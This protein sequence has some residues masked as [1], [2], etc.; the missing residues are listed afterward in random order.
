MLYASNG[1]N[2]LTGSHSDPDC[3]RVASNANPYPVSPQIVVKHFVVTLGGMRC[4]NVW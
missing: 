1:I 3:L 4:F 2:K